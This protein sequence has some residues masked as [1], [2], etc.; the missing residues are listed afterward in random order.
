MTYA[1]V[2]ILIRTSRRPVGFARCMESV[3]NQTYPNIVTI[4]HTDDPR[5]EYVTGDII[6]KGS[7]YPQS[8]GG[9]PYNLYC[10]ALLDVIPDDKPGWFCFLDDDDEYTEPDIIERLVKNSK[11][12]CINA[13]RVI[14]WNKEIFPKHWGSKQSFQSECFFLSTAYKNA[15]R[16][17]SNKGGDHF[18]TR[19][20]VRILPINWIDNLTAVRVQKGKGRGNPEKGI[21]DS[22][23]EKMIC[24][25]ANH[26]IKKGE[27]KYWLSQNE[28]K[29]LPYDMALEYEKAGYAQITYYT[30]S[31]Q[32]K[33]PHAV[34]HQLL[35][36]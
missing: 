19:Q 25:I 5:D 22:F 33:Y 21:K 26:E 13:C 15:A 2:Y 32:K 7:K 3:K 20:L 11:P 1:P 10:N 29:W 17:W 35:G 6:I 14:R 18:Y 23:S 8:V 31:T 30:N 34:L 4:V 27:R 36:R 12:D 16:W 24:V 9:A 28:Y